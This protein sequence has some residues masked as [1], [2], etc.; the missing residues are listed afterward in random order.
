[1]YDPSVGQF[2]SEDPIEFEG[3]DE[4]LKRY[5]RNRPIDNTDPTGLQQAPAP[6]QNDSE[7]P[8]RLPVPTDVGRTP[9]GQFYHR[10][11]LTPSANDGPNRPDPRPQ[12][13]LWNYT[14]AIVVDLNI[15]HRPITLDVPRMGFP[16]LA[17]LDAS[18]DQYSAL[19]AQMR[20]SP[21]ERAGGKW[22]KDKYVYKVPCANK[23]TITAIVR[24]KSPKI[25][26]AEGVNPIRDIGK[27]LA[28][29]ELMKV[30]ED[31]EF[32]VEWVR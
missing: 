9:A 10:Y 6:S 23:G 3:L 28:N 18:K 32:T 7:I 24:P 27:I 29:P 13:S 14:P 31:A 8:M 22:T 11:P 25:S 17:E 21:P 20:V 19:A 5:V 26:F 12:L 1:M 16:T 4:N 30:S 15:P 2:L